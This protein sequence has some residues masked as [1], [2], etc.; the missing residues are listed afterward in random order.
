MPHLHLY[1]SGSVRA[2][3]TSDLVDYFE[4][5]VTS[6]H[7]DIDSSFRHVVAETEAKVREEGKDTPVFI[8]VEE[9]EKVA[10]VAMTQGE[11]IMLDEVVTRD[12]E[13][14]PLV[15]GGRKGEKF[16]WAW[17]TRDG[18]WPELPNN[19]LS[20]N[21]IL[22]AVRAGQDTSDPIRRHLNVDC[23][24]TD[25]GRCVGM[26]R[27]TISM[28]GLS[29]TKPMD[30][31]ELTRRVSEIAGAIADMEKDITTPHL[32]LLVN[33]MYSDERKDEPFRRLQYLQ[34]W[35]AMAD[36]GGKVLGFKGKIRKSKQ[37][38]AGKHRL[39]ELYGYR[40]AIAHWW[41][42]LD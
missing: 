32:A 16:L 6:K 27:P 25:T 7:Y 40:N 15:S 26:T 31:P 8:V 19:Q 28:A 4:N 42:G 30:T 2:H 14:L 5:S 13:E 18:A 9:K 34:L 20:T 24:V 38:V 37:V 3:V 22:A 10:P 39:K 11:C 36:A 33:S 1:S 23:L 29:V 21:L 41:D 35:Q 12:G 17:H